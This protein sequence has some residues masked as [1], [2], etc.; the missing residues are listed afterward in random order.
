MKYTTT[1]GDETIAIEINQDDEIVIDGERYAVD[2]VQIGDANL[3]S[4]IIN[5]E[6]YEALVDE[7][8]GQW[9]V[10]LRGDLYVVEVADERAIRMAARTSS[11]TSDAAEV[12]IQA[13]MPGLVV[14][15]PV[16]PGQPVEAGDAVIILESMKMENELRSPRA[17]TVERVMVSPGDSVEIRLPS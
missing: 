2:F 15:V 5:N 14:T 17:G 3:Y 16:E 1:I 7:R 6:S 4:L 8:D 12:T 9:Q 11:L 13:P 10:L